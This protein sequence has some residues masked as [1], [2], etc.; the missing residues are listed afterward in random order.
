MTPIIQWMAKKVFDRKEYTIIFFQ[1]RK[2]IVLFSFHTMVLKSSSNKLYL[3]RIFKSYCANKTVY[4]MAY[5]N[6]YLNKFKIIQQ[7]TVVG[8][9]RV[10]FFL[11]CL[12]L[13]GYQCQ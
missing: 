5:T 4:T 11:H 8:I 10:S 13:D 12:M 6:I 9:S 3:I 7:L 1:Y 2:S